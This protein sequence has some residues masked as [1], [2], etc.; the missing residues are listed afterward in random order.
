MKQVI[1]LTA[2]KLVQT[3]VIHGC[4]NDNVVSMLARN[5]YKTPLPADIVNAIE[6]LKSLHRK[7]FELIKSIERV[8]RALERNTGWIPSHVSECDDEYQERLELNWEM[9]DLKD[10]LKELLAK[11]DQLKTIAKL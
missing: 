11:I 10:D 3:Y 7:R 2:K 5:G 8:D 4:V 6:E 1:R 9:R